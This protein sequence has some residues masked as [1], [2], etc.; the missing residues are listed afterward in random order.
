LTIIL[1]L[2]LTRIHL[3]LILIHPRHLLLL[4][5]LIH[6]VRIIW[7]TSWVTIVPRLSKALGL[8]HLLSTHV[9]HV[10]LHLIVPTFR[11]HFLRGVAVHALVHD[12]LIRRLTIIFFSL[13]NVNRL[14]LVTSVMHLIL[15]EMSLV[16]LILIWIIELLTILRL[17]GLLMHLW[18]N[19]LRRTC[20]DHRISPT[21]LSLRY[22][23]HITYLF[24]SEHPRAL[25]RL[26]LLSLLRGQTILILSRVARI[27]ILV[28][29]FLRRSRINLLLLIRI[30][31]SGRLRLAS[32]ER[33]LVLIWTTK[34]VN[35]YILRLHPIS[36][37]WTTPINRLLHTLW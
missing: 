2:V 5:I 7:H 28:W 27:E 13:L 10:L 19:A 34:L 17:L 26:N 18:L 4:L 15:S 3:L 33:S 37:S 29:A 23:E 20:T 16:P 12:S 32:V 9:K 14:I 8:I 36:R 31:L 24:I 30:S 1:A 6:H 22:S 11:R 25:H 35:S 21:H